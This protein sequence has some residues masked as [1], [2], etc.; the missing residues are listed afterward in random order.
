MVKERKCTWRFGV[1]VCWMICNCGTGVEAKSAAKA[2]NSSLLPSISLSNSL[3]ERCN[4]VSFS[5]NTLS[6][7]SMSWSFSVDQSFPIARTNYWTKT[8][9]NKP[10]NHKQVRTPQTS[11]S[12]KV[13]TNSW[14]SR[15]M[16]LFRSSLCLQNCWWSLASSG[17]SLARVRRV[18][19][20]E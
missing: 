13:V 1:G 11:S 19:F 5:A 18:A 2:F 17:L 10:R 12:K 4:L 14:M 8:E 9:I 3:T 15:L 7:S 6:S 20:S 16:V